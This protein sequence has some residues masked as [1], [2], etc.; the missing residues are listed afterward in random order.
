[1]TYIVTA[2]FED[3]NAILHYGIL[4]KS[5]RYPWGSGGDVAQRSKSF[6]DIFNSLKAQG[7]SDVDIATGFGMSTTQLRETRTLALAEKKAADAAFVQRLREKNVSN[8]EIARR[9][10]VSEGTVRNL[11]KPGAAENAAIISTVAGA[12]RDTVAEKKYVDVGKGVEATFGISKEKLTAVLA[13]LKDEGYTVHTFKQDVLGADRQITYKVL[14]AKGVDQKEVWLNRENIALWGPTKYSDD[15]G[16]TAYGILPPKELD[17]SRVMINYAKLDKDGNPTLGGGAADGVLYVRPGVPDVS[18]GSNRYAQVRVKVGPDHYLKGMAVYKDDLPDGIDIVFNTNK[19]KEKAPTKFDAM[20]PLRDDADNP[21]GSIIKRQI[22]D[23]EH[24]KA[25]GKER[26]SSC[27]NLLQEEGDWDGWSRTLSSQMLSK[28]HHVLAKQQLDLYHL[29]KQNDLEEILALT[30]P[31]VKRILLDKFADSADAASV[32][33]K[34]AAMPGQSTHVILPIDPKKMKPTEVY[35]PNF[36]NGDRVALIRHPHAGVFEIPELVVNNRNPTAKKLLG[37]AKDAIGINAKVAEKLSGADF[38]GDTV[39]VIPNRNGAIR[40]A[41]TLK[42]LKGFDAKT[43]Y[44]GYPGMVPMDKAGTQRH[45]GQISNLITDMTILG[46]REDEIAAAVRHSMVVIDAEKHKLNYKQSAID[47]NIN[48]LKKKY[49]GAANKHSVTLIS[50]A[51][52]KVTVPD[53]RPARKEE[54]GAINP[55]TGERNYV[56]TGRMRKGELVTKKVAN[57]SAPAAQLRGLPNDANR[58]VSPA[59]TTIEKVYA[60]HSNRM[61]AMANAARKEMLAVPNIPYNREARKTYAKE[62]ASLKAKYNLALKN[63]PLERQAVAIGTATYYEKLRDRPGMEDDE[64]KKVR[65]Q[66]MAQARARMGIANRARLVIEPREWEAIQA[67]AVT[68][69]ML[70]SIIEVA[71]LDAV[72]ELA[73]PRTPLLMNTATLSRAKSMAASGYTQAEIAGALGVSLTTLKEG[74]SNG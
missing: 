30:N 9:L 42:G 41:P 19:T 5:G 25:T 36:E 16:R 40:S 53:F 72:K 60:N 32:H 51:R 14:S 24:Y 17:P 34:A 43:A 62:V 54:G 22:I 59:G 4:R 15:N 3:E 1:M 39:L 28:Q 29:K 2:E 55:E 50:K 70:K 56:P 26:L 37:S 46:A 13:V 49:Q 21:F 61:K 23:E 52:G 6:I 65:H 66:S 7:L 8:V 58:L 68:N 74:L 48:S 27:M 71:D 35:A 12:L 64:K 11:Q 63:K 73:M 69:N 18:I 47:N 44:P 45:M 33:L 38:D 31:V 67:G 10:G 57:L 20:K